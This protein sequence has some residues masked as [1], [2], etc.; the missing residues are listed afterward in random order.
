M[1][2]MLPQHSPQQIARATLLGN[3]SSN[4]R[5]MIPGVINAV[6]GFQRTTHDD[7][8]TLMGNLF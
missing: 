7:D 4:D 2:Q 5:K 8:P 1:A 6:F 3:A